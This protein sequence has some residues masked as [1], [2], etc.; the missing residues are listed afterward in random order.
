MRDLGL[1]RLKDLVQ[2]ERVFQVVAPG[3]PAD[4]PPLITL[5]TLPNVLPTQLTPF[6]GREKEVA[7]GAA[8]LR[9]R[10][11]RLLTLTGPGG[12]GKTRLGLQI[13]ADVLDGFADGVYFVD[14][15]VVRDPALVPLAIA[16]VLNIPDIGGV[17]T[18]TSLTSYL[19][20]KQLLLVLDNCEQV[21][22]AAPLVSQ[23]LTAADGL[24]VLATSRVRL[25][26]VM[27]HTYAVPAL[28]L[29]DMRKLPPLP[30]FAQ[31]EA[32]EL[33]VERARAV[34]P[35][36]AVTE[37]SAP[38]VAQICVR[39]DGLPLAIELAAAHSRQ[40]APQALLKHLEQGM[41]LLGGG[42]RDLPTRQQTMK[43]TI[44]WSYALLT[45]EEQGVLRR[46]GVFVGGWTAEAAAAVC[47]RDVGDELRSLAEQSLI[48]Q[49]EE[50]DGTPR[51]TMLETVRAYAL[52]RLEKAGEA[53]GGARAA[54]QPLRCLL[55]RRRSGTSSA[56]A[57][58]NGGTRYRRTG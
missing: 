58:R 7:E 28:A 10:D 18:M 20:E 25:R 41:G 3:L 55:P 5:S 57:K 46:L 43:A 48:R 22:A 8:L 24:K 6:I 11:V 1:H 34:K 26:L 50:A 27:E 4:F 54:C 31:C 13:V 21:V 53:R 29:P 35:A 33:F 47:G 23:L 32:V 17:D 38:A 15:S 19:R 2:P 51:F 42:P 12:T 39:L 14:L 9:R 36:F 37:A 16:R 49:H 30:L 44:G 56:M 40:M 45:D 52:E